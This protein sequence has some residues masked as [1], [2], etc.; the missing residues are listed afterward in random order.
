MYKIGQKV[1]LKGT[2]LIAGYI[3]K[4]EIDPF[5]EADVASEAEDWIIYTV[6]VYKPFYRDGYTDFGCTERDIENADD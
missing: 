5:E 4:M 1:R 2:N 3:V 6:R